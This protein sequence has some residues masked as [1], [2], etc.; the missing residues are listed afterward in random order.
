MCQVEMI[1]PDVITGTPKWPVMHY[2]LKHR[3]IPPGP[4]VSPGGF[5][6]IKVQIK[7]D[8]RRK[9]NIHNEL[10]LIIASSNRQCFIYMSGALC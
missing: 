4:E 8:R 7:L 5:N 2:E 10:P 6:A 9:K 3:G 1:G